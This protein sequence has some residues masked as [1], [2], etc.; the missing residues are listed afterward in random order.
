M[1]DCSACTRRAIRALAADVLTT[2]RPHPRLLLTPHLTH[3]RSSTAA[4]TS[5]SN[6]GTPYL[7]AAQLRHEQKTSSD[8]FVP[9]VRRHEVGETRNSLDASSLETTSAAASRARAV[10]K[11]LQWLADPGKFADH[12]HYMLRS[13]RPEHALELCAAA[14]VKMQCVVAWNHCLDWH[15]QQG[16]IE[17]AMDIY[18]DMKKR[19]QFPDAYT[20]TLLLRG[21][22]GQSSPDKPV[23]VL[24]KHVS[25]ALAL[26][27][28][29]G[30]STSRVQPTIIH[31]NAA[32]KVCSFGH[33][34]DA[35]WSIAGKIPEQGPGAADHIT[36]S[37]L[38]N[39]LRH[40]I[41]R[42]SVH[43]GHAA[44]SA[45]RERATNE[46]RR[47]WMEVVR[48]WRGGLIKLDEELV[49]AMARLLLISD[50]LT[51]WDDV[52]SLV[53]Q[54]MQ[55]ERLVAP[56]GSPERQTGHVPR[57]QVEADDGEILELSASA[58]REHDGYVD[59]P[60]AKVFKTVTVLPP[61]DAADSK[62]SPRTLAYVTP[63]NDTLSVLIEAC[64]LMRTPKTAAAY[65]SLLTKEHNVQ[66]DV[67]NFN[68]QLRL[69]HKNRASAQAAR[70]LTEDLPA[71]GVTPMRLTFRFAMDT[72]QR[73]HKNPSSL[74]HA[75]SILNVMEQTLPDLDVET[76]KK[77]LSLALNTATGPAVVS[78]LKRL[79]SVTENL[80][81][82]LL[83][84][85]SQTQ[86]PQNEVKSKEEALGFMN[87]MVGAIDTIMNRGLVPREEYELWHR[88][89]SRT[90][91]FVQRGMQVVDASERKLLAGGKLDLQ[92]RNGYKKLDLSGRREPAE[93]SGVEN[94]VRAAGR[95]DVRHFD[96]RVKAEPV[97]GR[98]GSREKDYGGYVGAGR[99]W[100]S[101]PSDNSGASAADAGM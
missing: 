56:Y 48:K 45:P 85:P 7:N 41:Q 6:T 46:G 54:T 65:W 89:R 44:A 66:P 68:A 99:G 42:Q 76:V 72:C 15:M 31:T 91:Q 20:H 11:E 58:Q 86:T 92:G 21:L 26:Y 23:K 29:M 82:R 9:L 10:R 3:R 49:G 4:G 101:T 95:A 55:I 84:G 88:R 60:A 37:I 18:N 27:H 73:D 96:R 19:A 70:L 69:L 8:D 93:G 64:T 53:Q 50:R 34:M 67:H 33:D 61:P 16:R 38:L 14:S 94:R 79:D 32:L 100:R 71:S 13:D 98:G 1:L 35:L 25:R 57:Q 17:D 2:S 97:G 5:A 30:V 52:L 77:Y 78:A 40:E 59:T 12:V 90:V 62:R 22:A 36:Y 87:M 80:R 51:D 75:T 28:S 39:A 24:D 74:A 43:V 83:Y 81:S 47:V 63:G